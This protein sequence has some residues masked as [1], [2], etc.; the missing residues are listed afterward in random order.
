AS[1]LGLALNSF[2]AGQPTATSSAPTN[3][4]PTSATANGSVNPNGNATQYAFQYGPTNQYGEE[5]GLQSAGS[6]TTAQN[7]SA[8]LN[9]IKAG[10]HYRVV[11]LSSAGTVVGAD[12]TVGSGNPANGP[13]APTSNTGG[14]GPIGS[15]NA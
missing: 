11:A 14:S 8:T 9:G 15:D 6:G 2:A 4:T 13:K 10:Y 7:V 5:T 3:V 12:E 1:A